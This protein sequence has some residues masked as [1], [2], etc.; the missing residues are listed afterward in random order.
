MSR[1]PRHPRAGSPADLAASARHASGQAAVE[2][3]VLLPAVAVIL[4]LAW[5][6]VI[7]AQTAWQ[8]TVAARAA[9]R[10]HAVGTDASAAARAHLPKQLEHGLRVREGAD[11]RVHVSVR[12]PTPLRGVTLGRIGTSAHFEPQAG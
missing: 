3:V 1:A 2:V 5:Q 4:A 11:G 8:A 10:A 7:G 12:V 9:A 6:V